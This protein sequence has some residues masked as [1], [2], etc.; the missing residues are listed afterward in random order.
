MKRVLWTFKRQ[1]GFKSGLRGD[2]GQGTLEYILVLAVI[3]V[4]IL[5]LLYRFNGTFRNYAEAFF[6]SYI[7]CLLETGELPGTGSRC[8]SEYQALNAKGGK[9]LV[10]SKFQ[11]PGKGPNSKNSTGKGNKSNS[12]RGGEVLAGG[13]NRQGFG[14]GG[15]GGRS[16]VANV[17]N[18]GG[19]N[20]DSSG[21][22]DSLTGLGGRSVGNVQ[23]GRGRRSTKVEVS[24]SG[25]VEGS[26]EDQEEKKTKS[27]GKTVG[28]ST[29]LR[30]TRVI[31]T[32]QKQ[33]SKAGGEKESVFSIGGL[34]R[35]FI[36]ILIVVAMV[37]FFGGQLLQI[38]RSREKGGSD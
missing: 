5:S 35:I 30:P 4:L 38:M 12:G 32:S 22:G 20:D 2:S 8:Q 34:I 33:G 31:E 36:I 28:D 16:R 3:V 9:E 14:T 10:S 24:Y 1:P 15:G 25:G 37:I 23:D 18:V 13:G 27:T 26:K 11:A 29:R 6:D 19:G 7:A 17:G 21:S